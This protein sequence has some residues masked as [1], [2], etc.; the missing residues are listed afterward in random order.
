MLR[1]R[2]IKQE[3]RQSKR[4]PEN[5]IR[6]RIDKFWQRIKKMTDKEYNDFWDSQDEELRKYSAEKQRQRLGD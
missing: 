2:V 4:Q 1:N 5:P 3:A 6:R